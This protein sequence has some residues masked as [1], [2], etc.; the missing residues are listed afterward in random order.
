MPRLFN[1]YVPSNVLA[2]LVSELV[3]LYTCFI[4]AVGLRV[5]TDLEI[6]L[7]YDG[8]F[9]S[10]TVVVLSVVVAMYFQDLYAQ[11]QVRS[12]VVLVQQVCLSMG[13]ALLG[14]A[15]LSYVLPAALLPKWVMLA[16]S[17]LA[18]VLLPAWRLLYSAAM[19]NAIV[20]EGVLFVG[21]NPIVVELA[22]EMSKTPELGM[23]C[24]GF[25]DDGPETAELAGQVL[26]PLKDLKEICARVN[27]AR[28]VVGLTER[29]ARLPYQDLLELRYSGIRIEQASQLYEAAFGR[30]TTRELRPSELIFTAGLGP[31]PASVQFQAIY[32][33]LIG[34]VMTIVLSPLMVL[35]AI[36]V[37]L[38]S[39]GPI[40]YRQV[41]M[42]K[43]DKPFTIRKFRSMRQDAEKHTG[44]V[45]ATKNDP[46]ITPVGRWIRKTRL[47]ELPQLFNVLR[48]E[49]SIVGPRPERPEFT[50]TLEQKIPF[51]RQRTAVKP[52]VTGWAQINYKYG[53]TIE[54]TIAKLEYD[55]YYIKHMSLALDLYIVFSTVKTVLLRRGAQ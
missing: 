23:K 12:R 55:L 50:R 26:G 41:R 6:Y 9:A 31:D 1:V 11:V 43:D 53:D 39:P 15:L 45:W 8:G 17:G 14:Q 2:L 10:V 27:P 37:K 51:Y 29:R 47:D 36:L 19:T 18:L 35:T 4:G 54:D 13:V 3:L 24:L 33:W 38:T 7:R 46:R 16:G 22:A 48:G 20:A 32:S 34:F 42:G 5:P 21:T 40:L 52:G 25:V 30:V 44:A 28:I 49:M